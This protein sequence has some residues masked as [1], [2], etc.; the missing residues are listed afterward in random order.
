MATGLVIAMIH[1]PINSA[2]K[3]AIIGAGISGLACAT[4][5][6]NAGFNVTVFEKSKG[7]AGRMSTRM[8]DNWQCDHGTQYFTASNAQFAAEVQRWQQA[9]VATIWHANL[10]TYDGKTLAPKPSLNARYV[11]TPWQ[12]SPAWSSRES[13]RRPT[14]S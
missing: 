7:V 9:N 5:L 13:R 2:H 8:R 10:Q 6:Q 14:G 4:R 3:I 11:G 1:K 12:T